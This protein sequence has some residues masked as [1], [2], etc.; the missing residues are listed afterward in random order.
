MHLLEV[1]TLFER[2]GDCFQINF[3]FTAPCYA[4]DQMSRKAGRADRLLDP[5]YARFLFLIEDFG[6]RHEKFLFEKKVRLGSNFL[7]R[8][9]LLLDQPVDSAAAYRQCPY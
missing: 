3:R 2:S 6:P 7:L 5:I 4:V 9:D 8:K 1:L